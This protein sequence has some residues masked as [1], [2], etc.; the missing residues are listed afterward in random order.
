M[1][2]FARRNGFGNWPDF[3]AG[4]IGALL[5]VALILASKYVWAYA[6]PV[7]NY[8]IYHGV[9]PVKQSFS[10]DEP[11]VFES[12]TTVHQD[13]RARWIDTLY[14]WSESGERVK[15]LPQIWPGS[16]RRHA[17]TTVR[18]PLKV[19]VDSHMH[20]CRMCGTLEIEGSYGMTK[21]LTYRSSTFSVNGHAHNLIDGSDLTC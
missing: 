19:S 18:W 14:C 4:I 6:E 13:A 21:Y 11:F 15:S 2:E 5:V 16:I 17:R 20:F 3:K 9:E 7:D 1:V 8:A 10:L 12:D